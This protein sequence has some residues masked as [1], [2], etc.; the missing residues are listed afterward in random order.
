MA[1][2]L[3]KAIKKRAQLKA[4]EKGVY[5]AR[6]KRRK[7]YS[8]ITGEMRELLMT[9]FYDHPMVIVSPNAKDTLLVRDAA[10]EKQ[11][12][13]KVLTQVGLGT[14]FSDIVRENPMLKGKVGERSFRYIVSSTGRVRRFKESHK[15]MCGCTECV[16]M[17]WMHRSLQAKRT[18]MLKRAEQQQQQQG[19]RARALQQARGLGSPL[20]HDKPAKAIAE[21]A[22]PRWNAHAVPHWDCQTLQCKDFKPYPVPKEEP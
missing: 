19:R 10:G 7:G 15:Q 1:R 4:G 13:R 20:W 12:V 2:A 5:W 9:A 11:E 6:A 14:I 8:K 21:G 22:C 18:Q 17:H 3:P 16:G